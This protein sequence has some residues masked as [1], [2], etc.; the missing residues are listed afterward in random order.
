[1][2]KSNH[3]HVRMSHRG[4][5]LEMVELVLELGKLVGDKIVLNKKD[6]E[7]HIAE[8]DRKKRYFSRRGLKLS[9]SGLGRRRQ[10][11]LKIMDKGGLVVVAEDGTLITTY[12]FGNKRRH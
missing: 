2:K 3:F 5:T 7:G 10:V 6:L 4:V 1:M 9:L 8:I 11:A 12:H